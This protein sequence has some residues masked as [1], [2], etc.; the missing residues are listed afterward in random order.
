MSAAAARDRILARVRAACAHAAPLPPPEPIPSPRLGW[1]DFAAALAAAGGT[2]HEA[3][4]LAS[5][6]ARL[7]ALA[8][9]AP[10]L[11]DAAAALLG[12]APAT[13]EPRRL[14]ETPA[15]AATG[16]WAVARTG[17]VLVDHRDVPV[18]AHLLLPE[19]LILLVPHR[20]LVDDLQ[21]LYARYRAHAGAPGYFTL[22]T[23]PTKTADIEQHLVLGAHGPRRLD[24]IPVLDLPVPED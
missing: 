9:H 8:G 2:L 24:V 15:L 23:G 17:S 13:T 21:H 12:E 16:R 5:V 7:R 18:R 4:P 11:A 3:A 20:A 19:W 14:N 1:H 22:V 6:P 10:A